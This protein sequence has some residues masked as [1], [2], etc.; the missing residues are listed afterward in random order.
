MN[1]NN[2][3]DDDIDSL[4]DIKEEVLEVAIAIKIM[5]NNSMLLRGNAIQDNCLALNLFKSC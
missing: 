3:E 5:R 2:N 1:N 4:T